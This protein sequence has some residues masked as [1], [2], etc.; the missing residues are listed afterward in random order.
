MNAKLKPPITCECGSLL[1]EQE[2][3]LHHDQY[4]RS[5][6]PPYTLDESRPLKCE[7]AGARFD[8]PV[9]NLKQAYVKV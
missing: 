1:V 3:Y 6:T 5:A 9:I 8:F 7:W 4:S 2:G